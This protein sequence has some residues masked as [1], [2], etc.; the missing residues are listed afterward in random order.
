MSV[1]AW[2]RWWFW[3]LAALALLALVGGLLLTTVGLLGGPA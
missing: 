1:P 3:V 2:Q